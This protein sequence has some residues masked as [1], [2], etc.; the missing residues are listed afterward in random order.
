M[1]LTA[2]RTELN[3][4]LV[5]EDETIKMLE[6]AKKRMS[7]LEARTRSLTGATKAQTEAAAA[8]TSTLA[9]TNS[10]LVGMAKKTEGVVEGVDKVK[11]AFEKVVGVVGFATMAVSAAVAAYGFLQEAMS[12][13][14][15]EAA[16]L[17]AELK[18]QNVVME[19]TKKLTTELAAARQK[20]VEGTRA[21]GSALIQEQLRLAELEKNAELAAS[22]R[23]QLEHTQQ[24]NRVTELREQIAAKTKEQIDA[25]NQVRESSARLAQFEAEV[26]EKR[27]Q[28]E[29]L[30]LE[31]TK[32]RAEAEEALA[33]DS[34]A[35]GV[36]NAA[37]LEGIEGTERRIANLK[38]EI[39]AITNGTLVP[40]RE[41]FKTAMD[42]VKAL[43]EQRFTMS[44]LLGV[45][46]QVADAMKKAAGAAAQAENPEEAKPKRTGGGGGGK[47]K[48]ER[49]REK[50]ERE[51]E[52]RKFLRELFEEDN[53]IEA[54]RARVAAQA[55]L[56]AE[57]LAEQESLRTRIASE[58]A[59]LPKGSAFETLR[60]ELEKQLGELE[61]VAVTG[62]QDISFA[63]MFDDYDPDIVNKVLDG[64]EKEAL[65]VAKVKDALADLNE[66]RATSIAEADKMREAIERAM[67][68]DVVS[69]FA[70]GIESLQAMSV[71]AFGEISTVLGQ[72]Q[73]NLAKY[74]EGQQ[75]LTA[76][77]VGSSGAIAGAV[78]KQVGGVKAEA[79]VRAVFE[80]AM[81]FANLGNPALAAGHFT[82]AAMFGGL[83]T[84][85]VKPAA[86]SGSSAGGQKAPAA[87][88]AKSRD[89][90]GSSSGGTVTNVY[91]LNTGIVDGQSTAMAFRRAEMTARNTGM[92]S[93]G[94]W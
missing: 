80:T 65:A 76:S 54:A 12:G 11:G 67:P 63:R 46:Q 78:A 41:R 81:G 19:E 33:N 58:L 53:A 34:Y 35:A 68:A 87:P 83:A 8:Q 61:K 88:A 13:A 93:A 24:M 70:T 94:G 89:M 59:T 75:G 31:L 90:G 72:V 32:R 9:S 52:R 48:L 3:V 17:K 86:G 10:A 36:I 28:V 39:T 22:L 20:A 23:R 26:R 14:E 4:S 27:A 57:V 42:T 49:E 74:K 45:V 30:T 92:A 37:Q 73:A 1:A 29:Q 62:M 40:E 16:A 82:A 56:G 69:Q 5:G 6:D 18:R 7:D 79:A 55:N 43:R 85:L 50:R 44:G 91:N 77:I 2:A 84:G 64:H 60:K 47:S 71:E 21:G 25:D 51:F 38:T 15:K 66:M